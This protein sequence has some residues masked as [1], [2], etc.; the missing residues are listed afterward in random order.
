MNPPRDWIVI[1]NWDRFQHYTHRRPLWIKVYT[2]LLRKDEYLEL[3]FAERGLLHGIWLAYADRN[4][5]LK[6]AELSAV[7]QDR[8]RQA[9]VES[10]NHA[11]LIGVSASKPLSL[12]LKEGSRAREAIPATANVRRARAWI[13]NGAAAEIPKERL[14]DVIAD[15][16]RIA[17]P[18]I[19]RELVAQAQEWQP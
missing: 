8:A 11:G 2:D 9:H 1:P 12:D 5:L 18:D 19:V 3:S 17:E 10:L 16:F 14:A 15:E 6:T 7:L 13:H 4:G